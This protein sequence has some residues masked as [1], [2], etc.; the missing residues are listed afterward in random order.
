VFG[1][2]GVAEGE[3]VEHSGGTQRE[4]PRPLVIHV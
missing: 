4:A 2:E 1:R 3:V